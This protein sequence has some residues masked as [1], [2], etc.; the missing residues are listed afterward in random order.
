MSG[1]PRGDSKAKIWRRLGSRLYRW[2]ATLAV[3]AGCG[4]LLWHLLACVESPMA[5]SPE[6]DLA[7]TALGPGGG[8]WDEQTAGSAGEKGPVCRLFVLPKGEKNLRLIEET[9]EHFLCA[10]AYSPDGK[11][12]C[13]LRV[14]R[15]AK[16]SDEEPEPEGQGQESQDSSLPAIIS[17]EGYAFEDL[18]LPSVS[19]MDQFFQEIKDEPRAEV[20]LVARDAASGEIRSTTN[21]DL[22]LPELNGD[23]G[24]IWTYT[25]GRA[26]YGPDGQWIYLGIARLLL[27]VNPA[28][29]QLRLLAAP[30]FSIALSPDGKVVATAS[31]TGIGLVDTEGRRTVFTRLPEGPALAS[32]KG[33][34]WLDNDTVAALT[35]KGDNQPLALAL[36]R[37]DG[38]ISRSI[39]LPINDVDD[40]WEELAISP[41]R[42]RIALTTKTT[43]YL[44]DADGKVLSQWKEEGISAC[45][46]AFSPDS[47]QLACKLVPEGQESYATAIAFFSPEGKEL[48]RIDLPQQEEE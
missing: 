45:S 14:P 38:T 10:P 26:G 11:T 37:R 48:F 24:V 35:T 18:S 13:Y 4:V 28:A 39:E 46:P 5:F 19:Q 32:A 25:L 30:V 7:F 36:V 16:Q 27:A 6:G 23:D 44:L 40:Y 41:D 17:S 47:Q 33:V 29:R 34:A 15:K 8:P 21:L 2:K 42:T 12:L 43:L 22:A 31:E 3:L 20:T 1:T 9:N